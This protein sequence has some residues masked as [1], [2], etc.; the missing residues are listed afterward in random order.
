[1]DGTT[2]KPG[3]F[4][5][6]WAV[7]NSEYTSSLGKDTSVTFSDGVTWQTKTSYNGKAL[8]NLQYE[9]GEHLIIGDYAEKLAI[10]ILAAILTSYYSI[11]PLHRKK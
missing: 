7:N 5:F 3:L 4:K 1:M 6:E 2:V 8:T 9:D 10:I 11:A